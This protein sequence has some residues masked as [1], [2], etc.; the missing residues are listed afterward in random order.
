MPHTTHRLGLLTLTAGTTALAS[1]LS[2]L[3]ASLKFTLH[4]WTMAEMQQHIDP[5][6]VNECKLESHSH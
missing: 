6:F 2:A 1:A 4:I 3:L 5:A